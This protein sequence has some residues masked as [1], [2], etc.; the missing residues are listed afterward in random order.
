MRPH[1]ISHG[2]DLEL[3]KPSARPNNYVLWAKPR[4]DIVS[5]PDPVNRIAN[6]A[7]SF[8]FKSTHGR[9]SF[10]VQITGPMPHH[11]F[12]EMMRSAAV[13]LATTRET[14]DIASREAMAMA[15]PVCGWDHGATAELV[16]HKETGY[17]AELN[18]YNDL[19]EGLLYCMGNRGRLGRTA[20]QLIEERYQWKDIMREYAAVFELAASEDCRYP[21]K[22]SVIVPSYNYAHFLPDCIRSLA[23]QT[24]QDF[25]VIV[26][27]DGST[28]NTQT[29]FD[30]LYKKLNLNMRRVY[31]ENGG[32]NSALNRG[33]LEAKGRYILNLDAD[34]MLPPQALE[35]LSDALDE[36]PWL[37]VASGGLVHQKGDKTWRAQDWPF[38]RIDVHQQLH[39]INQ[40]TS[41]SMMRADKIK[42]FGGYRERMLRNEDGEWWCRLMSGGLRFE[43]VTQEPTL[44]YRWH[45]KRKSQ[46]EGGEHPID[47]PLSWNFYFPHKEN[48]GITP[49]AMTGSPSKGSWAVRSYANPH[50]AVCIPCGAE[51][52]ELVVDALDSVAGQTYQNIECIVCNDTDQPLDVTAMG[53]PW[54]RVI[55]GPR[56][57]PGA[58][59]NAAIAAAKAP[60]IVPL[61]ADDMLYPNAIKL[62]YL[63]W[64]DWPGLVYMDCEIED[65]PDHR[66]YY[67]SGPWSWNK[68][69]REAIYQVTT[70]YPKQWWEAVGG[71]PVPGHGLDMDLGFE[72]WLF[73]IKLHLAGID[74]VY[75]EQPWGVYR[76]W[77]GIGQSGRDNE[78]FGTPT[79]RP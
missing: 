33:Q 22:V 57:G 76:H 60:F 39:H 8:K 46:M 49:Y 23:N 55:Q 31:K 9:P 50:V 42:R 17:L 21:V 44:I 24:M 61:D 32:L 73:G 25:E 18:N 64:L 40:L 66:K 79:I 43:Q 45:D 34:N 37:D 52:L 36:R 78:G 54:V 77:T 14:G 1:V 19:A 56:K 5:N 29:V 27:D 6:I 10:N 69:R 35:I 51:H 30:N 41:S 75:V 47:G 16:I 13:W 28:D 4:T 62:M 58:A 15:I 20:R 12:L 53:H 63:A 48:K 74:A 26:V 2:V 59:R 11:K 71:Y 70:F 72:D 67:H 65:A 68:I 38:G 3:F 7:K